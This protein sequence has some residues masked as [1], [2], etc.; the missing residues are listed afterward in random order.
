MRRILL[1]LYL[2]LGVGCFRAPDTNE[3]FSES[4][5]EVGDGGVVENADRDKPK[6]TSLRMV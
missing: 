1:L 3:V 4:N 5:S 2:L 6:R